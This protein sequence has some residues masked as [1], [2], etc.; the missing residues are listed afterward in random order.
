MARRTLLRVLLEERGCH[1]YAAF[2]AEFGRAAELAAKELG[3][4]ALGTVTA[5]QATWKRW[6]SGEQMPRADTATVLEHWLGADVMTLLQ[7]VAEDRDTP[8][9]LIDE[10]VARATARDLDDAF[11][12]SSLRFSETTTGLEG[13]WYL[14]GRH[15]FDGT[16]LPVQIYEADEH[17]GLVVIGAADQPHVRHFIRPTRRA[18]VLAV[19]K[20]RAYALDAAYAK[21]SRVPGGDMLTIPSAYLVDQLTYALLWAMTNIDDSLQADDAVL[22]AERQRLGPYLG[23]PRSAMARAA[24]PELS[25]VSAAWLGMHVCARHITR[26]LAG[27]SAPPLFWTPV[28]SAEDAAAW[29]FFACWPEYQRAVEDHGDAAAPSERALYI[30]DDV[31]RE[32]RPHE[33]ILLWLGVALMELHGLEV[34]VYADPGYA[35]TDAF[36]VVPDT[37]VIVTNWMAEHGIWHVDTSDALTDVRACAELL[38]RARGHAVTEGATPERRLRSLADRLDLDW[39]WLTR[40]CAELAEFGTGGLLRP[41]SRLVDTAELDAVLAFAGRLGEAD[42]PDGA[43]AVDG[44]TLKRPSGFVAPNARDAAG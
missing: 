26:Q 34:R 15:R 3:R 22:H 31:L 12:G 41:R 43:P 11:G 29:L 32:A 40:R 24:M 38:D 28:P 36:V 2:D 23:Q 44:T 20:E 25:N 16:Q 6:L 13:R 10:D 37:K 7:T 21:R 4:P 18:L 35:R 1:R 14:S 5:S 8:R 42:P 27:T 39:E 30:P 33:R 19:S 17:D 9:S